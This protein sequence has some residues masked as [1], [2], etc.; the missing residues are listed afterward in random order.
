MSFKITK[1][2]FVTKDTLIAV[3]TANIAEKTDGSAFGDINRF[4]QLKHHWNFI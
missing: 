1:E 4:L 2:L 3:H